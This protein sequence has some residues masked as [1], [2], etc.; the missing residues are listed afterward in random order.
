MAANIGDPGETDEDSKNHHD[1]DENSE[2]RSNDDED[3]GDESNSSDH[4]DG[5][6]AK[7]DDCVDSKGKDDGGR[8]V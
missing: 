1:D 2:N 8:D 3:G 4:D 5:R 6:N 7:V